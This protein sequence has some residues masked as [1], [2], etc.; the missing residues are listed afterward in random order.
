[1]GVKEM[2]EAHLQNVAQQ[3]NDLREQ[4]RRIE[5][6]IQTLVEYHQNGVQELNNNSSDSGD[7]AEVVPPQ[8]DPVN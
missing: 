6:D 4:A 2:A 7:S 8:I 3:I 5:T 1:M